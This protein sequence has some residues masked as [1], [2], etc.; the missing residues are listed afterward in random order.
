MVVAFDASWKTPIGYFLSD[1]PGGS[2]K[3]NPMEHA[4]KLR[5]ACM[6]TGLDVLH[7]TNQ[8]MLLLA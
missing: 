2:E 6:V 3:K 4:L 7:F 5:M 1:T 8:N